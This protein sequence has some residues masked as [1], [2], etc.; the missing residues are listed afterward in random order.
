MLFLEKIF[1]NPSSIAKKIQNKKNS[2][3]SIILDNEKEL[4]N[5]VIRNITTTHFNI[6]KPKDNVKLSAL[7]QETQINI[8]KEKSNM[9]FEVLDKYISDEEKQILIATFKY[10]CSLSD[11]NNYILMSLNSINR[12]IR[13]CGLIKLTE[14]EKESD[15]TPFSEGKNIYF[16]NLYV[17]YILNYIIFILLIY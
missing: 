2:Y 9:I 11:S 10:Y 15:T 16:I 7:T 12:L 14:R 17:F 5:D 13:D 8:K 6:D 3:N 4:A 1:L